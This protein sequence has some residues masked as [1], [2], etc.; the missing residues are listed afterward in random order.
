[1]LMS[2]V[3][4]CPAELWRGQ[5]R[6]DAPSRASGHIIKVSDTDDVAIFMDRET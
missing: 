3:E 2:T 4:S 1:M 5:W 6:A